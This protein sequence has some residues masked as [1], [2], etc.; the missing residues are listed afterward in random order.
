MIEKMREICVDVQ[1]MEKKKGNY[2][3]SIFAL[4]WCKQKKMD[5]YNMKEECTAHK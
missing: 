2:C 4:D 1:Q 3:I 5:M